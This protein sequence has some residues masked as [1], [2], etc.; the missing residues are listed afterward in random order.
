MVGDKELGDYEGMVLFTYSIDNMAYKDKVRFYYALKG[1]D[2]KGGMLAKQGVT[3]LGRAVILVPKKL[4]KE[5]DDFLK[6]WKCRYEKKNVLARE[7]Q[8]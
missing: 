5:F 3:Q 6:E 1:R 7:A 8:Q 2:G 4:A